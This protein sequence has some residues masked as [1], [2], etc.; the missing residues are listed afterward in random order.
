[1]KKKILLFVFMVLAGIVCVNAQLVTVKGISK[2]RIDLTNSTVVGQ[3]TINPT[4][5]GK[6]IVRFD[7]NC[8]SDFGD[9]IIL[10]ASNTTSWG[11]NDRCVAVEGVSDDLRS[12]P[13][14]HTR[15]YNVDAGNHTFYAIAHNYVETEGSGKASIYGSLSV[16]FIPDGAYWVAFDNISEMD[17]NLA[18]STAVGHV[19]I[20]P[21]T[22]GRVIVHFD[23]QCI[24][25]PGDRIILA[26]SNTT[27]WGVNDG[28]V[29]VEAIDSDLN[30]NSFSHT[31]VYNVSA[32]SQTFYAIAQ[33]YVE[34]EG[35]GI[36][37]IY[38][39][40]TAVFIPDGVLPV[41]YDRI[42]ETN[43]DVTNVFTVGQV[44]INPQVAGRAFVHFDGMCYSS[45]GDRILLAAS[46][47]QDWGVNDGCVSVQAVN[48]DNNINSFSHTRAYDVDAG[49][50]TF[51][52]IA[53]NYV[54]TEGD[55]EVSVYG[56]LTV[57]FVPNATSTAI[58]DGFIESVVNIYPNPCVDGF[59]VKGLD[60]FNC[61]LYNMSGKLLLSYVD[62]NNSSTI[63]TD[64]LPKGTYLVKIKSKTNYVVKKLVVK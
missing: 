38:G 12:R 64:V 8:L 10:A 57:E 17:I 61:E 15:V 24:S 9:R 29:G 46:N 36:A 4:V 44:T 21:A 52:A 13:F 43:I 2:T 35:S 54:D 18:N 39:T 63:K 32:G 48:Q 51:Y 62:L 7:G 14:S 19:T 34:T 30:Q 41:S 1:M 49:S 37:S 42:L 28:N 53:H 33:N 20:N 58:N 27:S 23:G 40:L 22:S 50:N 26:A 56:M 16:E 45:K 5:S 47:V 25:D 55:G 59:K 60:N 6:V 3:V 11:I 31:R